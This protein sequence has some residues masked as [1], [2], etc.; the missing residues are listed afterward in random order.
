MNRAT[1]ALIGMMALVVVASGCLNGEAPADGEP[2]ELPDE[3]EEPLPEQPEDGEE[4]LPDDD[5][6]EPE[7]DELP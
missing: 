7:G 3:P 1:V 5:P 2:S 6:L 4:E